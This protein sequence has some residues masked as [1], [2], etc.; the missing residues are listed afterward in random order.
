LRYN[1]LTT[2]AIINQ[3]YAKFRS[4]LQTGA[5]VCPEA[6]IVMGALDRI[7][8]Q[9]HSF[10]DAYLVAAA[11][12]DGGEIASFDQGIVGSRDVQVFSL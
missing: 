11:M 9:K 2:Y 8:G 5:L 3:R 7:T 10:G 1:L 6:D 4:S 12:V